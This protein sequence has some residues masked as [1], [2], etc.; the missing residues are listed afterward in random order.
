MW[1]ISMFRLRQYCLVS[2]HPRTLLCR[3]QRLLLYSTMWLLNTYD[4]TL[5]SFAPANAPAYA[6]LSHVWGPEEQSFE[7]V[8]AISATP[9]QYGERSHMERLSPKIRNFC[10]CAL[11]RGYTWVWIDTCCI[12]KSSSAE[13]SE[14]LNSM[15]AW[16]AAADMCYAYLH[17]INGNQDPRLPSSSFRA[18]VWFTRGWTLQEL[19]A[20][21]TVVFL[22]PLWQTVGTS[23]SLA[24]VLTEITTIDYEVLIHQRPLSSVSVARRMSWASGRRTT[25]VEDRAYS[26][27]GIFGVCMHTVY[28]EGTRAFTRLQE[29]IL[30][31]IPDQSI[32]AWG[33]HPDEV[34]PDVGLENMHRGPHSGIYRARLAY[35][36]HRG[37][38]GLLAHSPED[39]S[40]SADI[41][42]IPFS[43]VSQMLATY[44]PVPVYHHNSGGL[45]VKMP[46]ISRGLVSPPGTLGAVSFLSVALACTD[47]SGT[48]VTLYLRRKSNNADGYWIGYP[49][50]RRYLR[51][52]LWEQRP[53]QEVDIQMLDLYVM[54]ERPLSA[55]APSYPLQLHQVSTAP[56]RPNVPGPLSVFF[57]F[58][59]WV[60]ARLQPSGFVPI[61]RTAVSVV[62]TFVQVQNWENGVSIEVRRNG[63]P[64]PT[65][66][67]Q[68]EFARFVPGTNGMS[69]S[70]FALTFWEG[71]DC[72]DSS[73]HD[74]E[75]IWMDITLFMDG[76]W[77]L[78]T[79]WT[80]DTAP[81]V[82]PGGNARQCPRAHLQRGGTNA[83][84]ERGPYVV[85]CRVTFSC[86]YPL[87]E[88]GV[89]SCEFLVELD[90]S[91]RHMHW[92]APS[93]P[94]APVL[95]PPTV[96]A[97]P[98]SPPGSLPHLPT[99]THI[100][101]FTSYLPTLPS[102]PHLLPSYPPPAPRIPQRNFPPQVHNSWEVTSSVG[103]N[104]LP[105]VPGSNFSPV[106]PLSTGPT[107]DPPDSSSLPTSPNSE[108]YEP[109]H[110]R[111]PSSSPMRIVDRPSLIPTP[112]RVARGRPMGEVRNE[113]ND[114]PTSRQHV[115]P[116]H[117]V[118][119]T[120][121]SSLLRDTRRPNHQSSRSPVQRAPGM[122]S[123]SEE[124]R[125]TQV[126]E[127]P[128]NA[129]GTL[130]EEQRL[131]MIAPSVRR[132]Q[133]VRHWASEPSSPL[134]RRAERSHGVQVQ[135]EDDR[136]EG[137][138][139][140]REEE[141]DDD[142][143]SVITVVRS[144]SE[145]LLAFHGFEGR[146]PQAYDLT[147]HL[148]QMLQVALF[149]RPPVWLV[150]IFIWC[151]YAGSRYF[152]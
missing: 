148:P 66:I 3:L 62:S 65:P 54:H 118:S 14:A 99:H 106:I 115:A 56:S 78:P 28:G 29:E 12:N 18:S 75:G 128:T 17:D 74:I 9:L 32:F 38:Q 126:E 5:H 41:R 8:M 34:E 55:M 133:P 47:R 80:Q 2:S 27:M 45:R 77:Q 101:P 68:Q 15:Y 42:P 114:G 139:Q 93:M 44:V 129:A 58:P 11:S 149:S 125:S 57:L 85:E 36:S 60:L 52:A 144:W 37:L 108:V 82:S 142:L 134:A 13:L 150:V 147:A 120:T 24:D 143:D 151:L 22:S 73:Q 136:G 6:I 26:L 69:S 30:K 33:H 21:H 16:Y 98:P 121:T 123:I 35:D 146:T 104:P 90:V 127:H 43:R 95:P 86:E 76:H 102:Y 110:P 152:D 107:Y 79:P 10:A 53:G 96:P 113:P 84:F 116:T 19:L 131:A 71:C 4:A 109:S 59:V 132:R 135:R 61:H 111:P 100:S 112:V 49:T 67:G 64:T 48:L 7:E 130:S 91:D 117:Q 51:T 97:Q 124:A 105:T 39:F 89:A 1:T 72:P 20:P 23:R 140:Q 145:H 83:R 138:R 88:N 87:R 63:L 50:E 137:R 81:I 94:Q 70:T 40:Q 31:E 25:R 119:L 103:P 122:P 141:N 46:V 92:E